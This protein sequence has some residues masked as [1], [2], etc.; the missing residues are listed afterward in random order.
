MPCEGLRHV[1]RT[2][3]EH[4]AGPLG[5]G[6]QRNRIPRT[7]DL[8]RPGRLEILQ[9]Q[10]DLR[11]RIVHVESEERRADDQSLDALSG[12][13]DRSEVEQVQHAGPQGEAAAGAGDDEPNTYPPKAASQTKRG[14]RII[15]SIPAGSSPRRALALNNP[16]PASERTPTTTEGARTRGTRTRAAHVQ[17]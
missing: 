12:G 4:A 3:R 6:E 8:E 1:S 11:G 5:R 17:A 16:S 15:R 14:Q 7:A 2:A 10:V 9:L 13:L